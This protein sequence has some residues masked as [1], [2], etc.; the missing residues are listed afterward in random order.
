[1]WNA[2]ILLFEMVFWIYYKAV[3][4]VFNQ[5]CVWCALDIAIHLA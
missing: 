4:F 1:M 2:L 3:S 5:T